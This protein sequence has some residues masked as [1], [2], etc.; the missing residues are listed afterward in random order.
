MSHEIFHCFGALHNPENSGTQ[1]PY[2]HGLQVPGKFRTIMAYQCSSG[3]S[4]PR[5][6]YLSA[7]G[8]SYNGVA[9]GDDAHDNARLVG[10]NSADIAAFKTSVAP[11]RVP[12]AAPVPRPAPVPVPRPVPQPLP[13]PRPVPQ[14]VPVPRPVPQP[15]PVPRPVP[16]AVP[17]PVSSSGTCDIYSDPCTLRFN[18]VCNAGRSCPA[19]TDCFDCDPLQ[20]Y[21]NMGC[22]TCVAKGGEY[23][24]T[25]KGVPFCSSPDIARKVPKACTATGG[26]EYSSICPSVRQPVPAPAPRPAPVPVPRPAP[27]PPPVPRPAPVP[28]PVPRL[29]PVQSPL[30]SSAKCDIFN[31]KCSYKFDLYCDAGGFCGRDSDCFDCDPFLKFRNSGCSTCIAAGGH[32]CVTG[33]GSS[34]CNS[35][36]IA[37]QVPYACTVS[38]GSVYKSTCP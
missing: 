28:A 35:P 3:G 1:H 34:F 29:V 7:N 2:G 32:Y 4:C 12:V 17:A 20:A 10:E 31:D 24:L 18:L 22:E 11:P 16:Q 9:L 21:R 27:V 30:S 23:C 36:S 8:F 5:I 19:G 6:P 25:G 15:V 37:A 14:P 26:S 38:G 13:V 33:S